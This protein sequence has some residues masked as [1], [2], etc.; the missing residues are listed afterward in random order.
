MRS[1]YKKYIT[2]TLEFIFFNDIIF[3]LCN[4]NYIGQI[5]NLDTHGV[6]EYN[7]AG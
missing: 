4:L 3:V 7:T 5:D 1:Y 6:V 2:G